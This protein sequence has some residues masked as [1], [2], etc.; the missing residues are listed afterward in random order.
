MQL[1]TN[2]KEVQG[3]DGDQKIVQT[4]K[5]KDVGH[6]AYILSDK[7]YSDKPLAVVREYVCNA[8]DA[9]AEAGISDPIQITP[10]THISPNFSVRDFGKGITFDEMK[11]MYIHLGDSSKRESNVGIGCF[12]I[13]NMAFRA[14]TDSMIVTSYNSGKK[15]VYSLQVGSDNKVFAVI[16]S[17]TPMKDG[18]RTGVEICVPIA[19]KDIG[20]FVSKVKHLAKHMRVKPDIKCED[21]D[22]EHPEKLMEG[23]NYYFVKT[24]RTH[25]YKSN[26]CYVIMGDVPYKVDKNLIPNLPE[27][28]NRML[29]AGL[30]IKAELGDVDITPDREKLEFSQKTIKYLRSTLT[31]IMN[32]SIDRANKMLSEEKHFDLFIVKTKEVKENCGWIAIDSLKFQGNDVASAKIG[33]VPATIPIGQKSVARSQG[34]VKGINYNGNVVNQGGGYVVDKMMIEDTSAV[35]I[36]DTGTIQGINQRLVTMNKEKG[37]KNFFVID[38]K[39]P[40]FSEFKSHY[41]LDTWKKH[42]LKASEFEKTKT[43]RGRSYTGTGS[44]AKVKLFKLDIDAVKSFKRSEGNYW[45][46]CENEIDQKETKYYFPILRYKIEDKKAGDLSASKLSEVFDELKSLGDIYGVRVSDV[47]KLDSTWVNVLDY[48]RK[49]S[50]QFLKSKKQKKFIEDQFM[51]SELE[52]ISGKIS[53]KPFHDH[54]KL[55]ET[56]NL[57]KI[58]TELLS[59]KLVDGYKNNYGRPSDTEEFYNTIGEA[60]K[61]TAYRETIKKKLESSKIFQYKKFYENE[62]Y[63]LSYFFKNFVRWDDR[64]FKNLTQDQIDDIVSYMKT[65]EPKA[66]EIV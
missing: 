13:G 41:H 37:F 5:A 6:I 38:E 48:F 7:L 57:C 42:L 65:K 2:R 49:N 1:S 33:N 8:T 50:D 63:M 26:D 10:P 17:E 52:D 15:S 59:V 19:D 31:D 45:S 29:D 54:L 64:G 21:F 62:C 22:F 60:D 36:N 24:E 46:D 47:K 51:R 23:D 40:K 39:D 27:K 53:I 30:V 55:D 25:W 43:H 35:V 56:P 32:D 3:V 18:D 20:T 66:K 16:V 58:L 61:V 28:I 44:R 34:V 14:Y 4:I 9:H 11:N 12:G